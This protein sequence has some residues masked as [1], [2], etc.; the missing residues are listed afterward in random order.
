MSLDLATAI[1]KESL[2][3]TAWSLMWTPAISIEPWP[4]SRIS[5]VSTTFSW[6]PAAAVTILKMLPGS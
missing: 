5:S 2:S 1:R 4:Q 6:R 3:K